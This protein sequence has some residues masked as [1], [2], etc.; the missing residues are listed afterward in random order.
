MYRP[1]GSHGPLLPMVSFL[2]CDED[3]P[4]VVYF[5]ASRVANATFLNQNGRPIMT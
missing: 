2:Y 5:D 3:G 1:L 4:F